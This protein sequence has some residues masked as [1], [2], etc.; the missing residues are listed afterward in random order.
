MSEIHL[1]EHH[2][3]IRTPKQLIITVVLAFLIPIS[4]IVLLT[5][6]LTTGIKLDPNSNVMMPEYI[7]ERLRPVGQLVVASAKGGAQQ[8][9]TGEQVVQ[10][11]CSACH[12]TGAL[13]APKIGDSAAWGKVAGQGL[14]K[15]IDHAIHGVRQMP[16]RGG[17]ATLSDLEVAR[18]VVYMANQSGQKFKEPAAPAAAAPAAAAGAGAVDGKAIYEKTCAACHMTGAA[19]APKA[20]DKAAWEARLKQGANTLYEHAIKGKGAMPPKGGNASLS[21][22]EVK[23]AVDY[24]TSLAK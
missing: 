16:A 11:T 19:N 9:K 1:E 8:A 23:A 6:L 10:A 3:P 5:Q 22:A 21:D 2:S 15:L 17:N 14:D 13:N 7:A 24:L 4:I 18:A 12:A 20:G